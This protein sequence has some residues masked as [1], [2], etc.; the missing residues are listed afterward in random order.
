MLTVVRAAI[1]GIERA[2]VGSVESSS[3]SSCKSVCEFGVDIEVL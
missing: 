2:R 3:A 1:A